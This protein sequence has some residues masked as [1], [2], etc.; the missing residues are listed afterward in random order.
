MPRQSDLIFMDKIFQKHGCFRLAKRRV[1]TLDSVRFSSQ[2]DES[3]GIS[4]MYINHI[5]APALFESLLV[6]KSSQAYFFQF[7]G[8]IS[9]VGP[10]YLYRLSEVDN[11]NDLAY[12]VI[13]MEHLIH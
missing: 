3:I 8:S 12:F 10:Y 2:D 1:L 5:K 6:E 7:K 4:F 9:S 11:I 13:A